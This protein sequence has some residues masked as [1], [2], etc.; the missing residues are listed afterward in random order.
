MIGCYR[1]DAD[2]ID[3]PMSAK[4]KKRFG[5]WMDNHH[6]TVVGHETPDATGFTVL[7]H[8]SN[9]GAGGNSSENAANHLEMTL[10]QKY[11]KEIGALMVNAEEV[12]LTGTGTIQEQFTHYLAET[13]QFKNAVT[14]D[15]TS[16]KM[17]DEKLVEFIGARFN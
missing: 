13:P 8:V 2:V 3:G 14:T 6:A 11:F 1:V 15:C 10:T 17:S 5:V 4:I 9:P 16:N 12:H 7:G